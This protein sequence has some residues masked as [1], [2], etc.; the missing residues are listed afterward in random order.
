MIEPVLYVV[1]INA[2]M[3]KVYII[4]SSKVTGGE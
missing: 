1:L 4:S 3:D 2:G